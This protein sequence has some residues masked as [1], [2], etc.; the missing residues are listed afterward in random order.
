MGH[1][2][3]I[4]VLQDVAASGLGLTVGSI[5]PTRDH[6]C[7]KNVTF[8][9][10][11]MHHTYKGIYMKSGNRAHPDPQATAEITDILYPA[12]PTTMSPDRRV[13]YE[14]ITRSAII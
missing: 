6:A 4:L 5:E 9:R 11:S 2:S 3:G 1:L 12:I 13:R 7:I 14:K 10:A 8:R